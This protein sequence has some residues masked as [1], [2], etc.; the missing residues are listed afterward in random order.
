MRSTII[1]SQSSVRLGIYLLA[2]S[3][4][5]QLAARA[6]I[7]QAPPPR[8]ITEMKDTPSPEIPLV[9]APAHIVQRIIANAQQVGE[10]LAQRDVSPATRGRQTQILKDIETLLQL[11]PPSN[12]DPQQ[13][14]QKEPSSASKKDPGSQTAS[15]SP[16]LS[17]SQ[18]PSPS[19]SQSQ[20]GMQSPMGPRPPQPQTPAGTPPSD[21]SGFSGGQST[22]DTP[23]N[24][25]HSQAR[26]GRR[27]RLL[28]AQT[29]PLRENETKS[30]SQ[31]PVSNSSST[32]A[33]QQPPTAPANLR[34]AP[35]DTAAKPL[36]IPP[37]AMR[38]EE[39]EWV[40]RVWGHL[41][42]ALRRQAS[43]YYRQTFIPRYA[44][45]LEHYYSSRS[46]K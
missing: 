45:L 7:P 30:P 32:P 37:Q 38:P 6:D 36:A 28:Q 23:Q 44:K 39:P 21:R 17:E 2:A 33:T 22:Q 40:R 8:E 10:K 9:Q 43:E 46:D 16:S 13:A 29:S 12:N 1:A 18:P 25:P 27:P 41:P 4:W 42:D 15:R 11:E 26:S 31:N 20:L 34:T 24:T 19:Q 35:A 14:D 5:S 3:G